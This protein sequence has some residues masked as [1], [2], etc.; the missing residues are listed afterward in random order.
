ML[1]HS[2]ITANCSFGS[3]FFPGRLSLLSLN[4]LSRFTAHSV[5]STFILIHNAF[6]S[7]G[8]FLMLPVDF[9]DLVWKRMLQSAQSFLLKDFICLPE[10]SALAIGLSG[11]SAI[12]FRNPAFQAL[13]I[14][15]LSVKFRFRL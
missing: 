12:V 11:S 8:I 14:L 10:L 4:P 7:I 13:A 2:S 3:F 9:P 6:L 5:Q 1:F 15:S